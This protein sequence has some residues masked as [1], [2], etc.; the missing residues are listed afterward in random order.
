MVNENI[1][2]WAW[3]KKIFKYIPINPHTPF[4][5]KYLLFLWN[6]FW[7][8]FCSYEMGEGEMYQKFHHIPK[9]CFFLI[10]FQIGYI[11]HFHP[12]YVFIKNDFSW[13]LKH[14]FWQS[15]VRKYYLLPAGTDFL[16]YTFLHR[17][18]TDW[19]TVKIDVYF[20]IEEHMM[21]RTVSLT[22][23]STAI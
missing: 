12:I 11:S 3:L 6:V 8:I 21:M 7:N 18:L 9:I 19:L 16:S 23:W 5:K 13:T 20:W 17:L 10:F 15:S 4:F 22:N 1:R 2:I 14:I